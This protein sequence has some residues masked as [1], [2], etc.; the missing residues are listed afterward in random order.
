VS[1]PKIRPPVPAIALP[2]AE[3]A[4]ALGMGET[5]FREHVAPEVRVIFRGRMRLYPVGWSQ[6]ATK[7]TPA[8][9]SPIRGPWPTRKE[10][11][12]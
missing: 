7:L 5:A 4:A 6:P 8:T 12:P 3:A 1:A 11:S 2:P 9:V 10:P